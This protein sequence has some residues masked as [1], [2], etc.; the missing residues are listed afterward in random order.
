MQWSPIGLGDANRFTTVETSQAEYN[1]SVGEFVKSTGQEV[2]LPEPTENGIV[3]V[4]NVGPQLRVSAVSGLVHTDSDFR[5]LDNK[6]PVYLVSDGVNWYSL[7]GTDGFL[8]AIP[9]NAIAN[10]IIDGLGESEWSDELENLNLPIVNGSPSVIDDFVRIEED[11][12]LQ[13]TEQYASEEPIGIVFTAANNSVNGAMFDGANRNDFT[14]LNDSNDFRGVRGGTEAFADVGANS[15]DFR[16]FAFVGDNNNE[17]SLDINGENIGSGEG[18]AGDLT[19]LTVGSAGDQNLRSSFDV[20][21]ITVL[22]EGGISDEVQR[23]ANNHD[24]NLS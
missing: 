11:D 7:S 17:L 4:R 3:V 13:Q 15:T 20:K 14:F 23:Q 10:Y 6:E 24:I 8:P 19:G 2:V 1:A 9:D 18:D 16:V 21:E 22:A 12:I 5:R